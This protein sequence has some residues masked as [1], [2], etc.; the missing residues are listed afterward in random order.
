MNV[1]ERLHAGMGE[2]PVTLSQIRRDGSEATG[3]D[4]FSS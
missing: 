1:D 3:L 4:V 2:A